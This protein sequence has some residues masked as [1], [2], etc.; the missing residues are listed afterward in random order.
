MPQPKCSWNTSLST[1]RGWKMVSLTSVLSSFLKNFAL[2]LSIHYT[3]FFKA[4]VKF[5]QKVMFSGDA[6]ICFF[7]M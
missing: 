3:S 5:R 2:Y 6:F 7:S 4:F 1:A